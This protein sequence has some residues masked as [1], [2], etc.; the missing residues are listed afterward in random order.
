MDL[1]LLE[2]IGLELSM[3][4]ILRGSTYLG[5]DRSSRQTTHRALTAMTLKTSTG[6]RTRMS[7]KL[8][9]SINN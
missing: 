8:L 3:L 1:Y 4:F 6:N 2:S 9:I 7:R 5:L